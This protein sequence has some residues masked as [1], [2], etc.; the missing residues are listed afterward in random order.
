MHKHSFGGAG[1]A[2][3][4]YKDEKCNSERKPKKM[5]LTRIAFAAGRSPLI[6]YK[7]ENSNSERKPK[8]MK[9]TRIA[10]AAGRSPLR[11]FGEKYVFLKN[12]VDKCH[13]MRYNKDIKPQD[14][15]SGRKFMIKE[16][17][18]YDKD[19]THFGYR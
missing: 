18:R 2:L 12:N 17:K 11:F 6:T 1:S 3:I 15:A 7:D 9:L 4:T 10:F 19:R 5:K 14:R 16:Y 13:I 8:K